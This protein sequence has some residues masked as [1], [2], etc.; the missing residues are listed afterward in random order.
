MLTN[1]L[2]I[3]IKLVGQQSV[4]IYIYMCVIYIINLIIYVYVIF[5]GTYYV[6]T[7]HGAHVQDEIC[8]SAFARKRGMPGGTGH[9]LQRM[10]AV[11]N[12]GFLKWG[13]PKMVGLQWKTLVKWMIKRYPPFQET[14]I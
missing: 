12:G 9:E 5:C 8:E 3:G 1:E 6:N 7:C 11:L 2:N 4:L 13:I 14:S 10:A